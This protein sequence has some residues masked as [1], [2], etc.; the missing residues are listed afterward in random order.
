MSNEIKELTLEL[1]KLKFT[2]EKIS[3]FN[4][5]FLPYLDFTFN[6]EIE[7]GR[8]K[9]ELKES[10]DLIRELGDNIKNIQLEH[11]E[12]L[13][14]CENHYR[15]KL[16]LEKNLRKN[17]EKNL[18]ETEI[19]LN[20]LKKQ[21]EILNDVLKGFCQE[22]TGNTSEEQFSIDANSSYKLELITDPN[23]KENEEEVRGRRRESV[24]R[25]QDFKSRKSSLIPKNDVEDEILKLKYELKIA[26]EE[27]HDFKVS[28]FS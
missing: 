23:V 15:E 16:D 24:R 25:S 9:T 11:I 2:K 12:N 17:F 19:S 7:N 27:I 21:N 26:N 6:L 1:K 13:K 8:L 4:E 28:K 18:E 5:I 10:K 3:E 14:T 20:E 22:R